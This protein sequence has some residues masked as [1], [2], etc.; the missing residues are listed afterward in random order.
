M[1]RETSVKLSVLLS[2]L[3]WLASFGANYALM[4]TSC[5]TPA[6]RSQAFAIHST[7]PHRTRQSVLARRTRQH[8]R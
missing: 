7:R 4:T 3:I 5:D 1:K 8:T 6:N 2:P